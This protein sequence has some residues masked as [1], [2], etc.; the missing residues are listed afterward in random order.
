MFPIDGWIFPCSHCRQPTSSITKNNIS[1]CQ[2]C[3]NR[4]NTKISYRS[5]LVKIKKKRIS[6]TICL[7]S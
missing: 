6:K 3:Q 1:M 5:T 4:T 2:M 7:I